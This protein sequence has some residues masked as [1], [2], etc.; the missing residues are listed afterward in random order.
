MIVGP[1]HGASLP[2][3]LSRSS[4]KLDLYAADTFFVESWEDLVGI[5]GD[6]ATNV[7]SSMACLILKPDAIVARVGRDALRWL[8]SEGFAVI[9]AE[10]VVF[11]RCTIREVWRYAWNAAT[12]D[13]KAV[14]DLLMSS[15]PSLFVALVSSAPAALRLSERKGASDPSKRSSDELREI[16]G[17]PVPLLNFVHTADEAADVIR[18]IGV[19]FGPETRRS[20]YRTALSAPMD[21]SE[22]EMLLAT[23]ETATPRHDLL[24]EPAIRRV[25]GLLDDIDTCD[26]DGCQL[27]ES[28][29]RM[30]DG[31][32]TDSCDVIRSLN[33]P[34]L[35]HYEWDR[36]VIA[37]HAVSLESESTERL[38]RGVS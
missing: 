13:R 4:D 30:L 9:A 8:E 27:R 17:A 29:A 2:R 20:L 10:R 23:I 3:Q 7:A 5:V 31:G 32:Q 16:L 18:E 21:L 25:L 22:V 28:L 33:G 37:T 24:L 11:D 12:R 26:A 14:M 38:L 34:L 6:G 15:T 1:Q 19:L 36:I 35:P